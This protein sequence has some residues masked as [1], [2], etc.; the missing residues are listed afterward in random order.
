MKHFTYILLLT[1][2]LFSIWFLPGCRK[3]EDISIGELNKYFFRDTI[4]PITDNV[5][6]YPALDMGY[7]PGPINNPF[8]YDLWIKPTRQINILDESDSCKIEGTSALFYSDQN[9]V[10]IPRLFSF[11]DFG[12]GLSV[13]TNGIL[14]AEFSTPSDWSSAFLITRLSYEIPITDWIH[15]TLVY[16]SDSLLLYLNGNQMKTKKISCESST[17]C[18]SVVITGA[19]YSPDFKGNVDEFRIW[20]IALTSEEVKIIMNKK[21]LNQVTGLR[22]YI[23]FDNGTFERTLGD[24]GNLNLTTSYITPDKNIKSS[25]WNLKK[26]K[27]K[28]I[29]TL[30]PY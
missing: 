1:T 11:P 16:R 7:G 18:T 5:M 21:L 27:G 2:I 6:W 9:W 22:F 29:S 8:S 28:T 12:T 24:I 10:I 19:L 14:V 23:S 3:H 15:V 26:Y 30:V 4:S 25:S 20:D 17:K 13:G